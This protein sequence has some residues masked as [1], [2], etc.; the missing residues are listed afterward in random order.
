MPDHHQNNREAVALLPSPPVLA[1]SPTTLVS[2]FLGLPIIST[3]IFGAG[4]WLGR[5]WYHPAVPDAAVWPDASLAANRLS[6]TPVPVD[7]ARQQDAPAPSLTTVSPRPS[8]PTSRDVEDTTEPAPERLLADIVPSSALPNDLWSDGFEPDA[9]GWRVIKGS[10]S[11]ED[12]DDF[13]AAFPTSRFVAA[14]R[15]RRRHLQSQPSMSSPN[16]PSEPAHPRVEDTPQ[17]PSFTLPITPLQVRYA[18][19]SLRLAGFDPGPVDG[20]FGQRT[21][22]AMRQYQTSQGL[23]V[24]ETLDASTQQALQIPSHVVLQAWH[25]AHRTAQTTPVRTAQTR[26][27]DRQVQQRQDTETGRPHPQAAF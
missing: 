6:P 25:Q 8:H 2:L 3:A 9:E 5:Q 15:A 4:L 18:Q 13:M 17:A 19:V 26:E 12:F 16:D 20:I 24:T 11:L 7:A 21:R 1:A 27:H 22:V 14:A 10:Q 23:A